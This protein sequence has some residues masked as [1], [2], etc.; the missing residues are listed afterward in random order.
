MVDKIKLK[1]TVEYTD[2]AVWGPVIP[3]ADASKIDD[4]HLVLGNIA[5][6]MQSVDFMIPVE[7]SPNQCALCMF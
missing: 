2:D 4:I 1:A 5:L 7:G 3:C 6:E